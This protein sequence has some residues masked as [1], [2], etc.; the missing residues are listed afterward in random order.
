MH[1]TPILQLIVCCLFHIICAC[2][3][4]TNTVYFFLACSRLILPIQAQQTIKQRKNTITWK[5]SLLQEGQP[6]GY[7]VSELPQCYVLFHWPL[8]GQ[9]SLH[10]CTQFT[11]LKA[12]TKIATLSNIKH[13]VNATFISVHSPYM[14]IY[15]K[16]GDHGS[17]LIWIV[18]SS[19]HV[20]MLCFSQV[21]AFLCSQSAVL[22]TDIIV[23]WQK[24]E[25]CTSILKL[26]LHYNSL[27]LCV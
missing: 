27:Q 4:N 23:I 10:S 15:W 13:T 24:I 25:R 26:L 8:S 12:F 2:F 17:L 11:G 19:V 7:A 18:S 5:C 1:L 9:C 6:C 21:K 22:T 16:R 3:V 20:N 14:A